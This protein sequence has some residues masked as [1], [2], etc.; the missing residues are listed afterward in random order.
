MYVAVYVAFVVPSVTLCC[1][2]PPSDQFAN[3][4][5]PCG[6][7]AAIVTVALAT[8]VV[9]NGDAAATPPVTTCK[10]VGFVAR[11]SCTV[12]GCTCIDADPAFPW[13]SVAVSVMSK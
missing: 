7:G 5:A 10:P 3:V 9:V 8:S 6:E 1:C 11:V 4:H 12:C 2:A 13:L